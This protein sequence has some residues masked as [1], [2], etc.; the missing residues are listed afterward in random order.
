M[1]DFYY[2]NQQ[3]PEQYVAERRELQYQ[4]KK[5]K[6]K[7]DTLPREQQVKATIKGRTLLIDNVPQIKS[8]R[9]PT[10]AEVMESHKE[11]PQYDA[12]MATSDITKEK[13]SVFVSYA[14]KV[15]TLTHISSA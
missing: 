13:G 7:N 5:I 2:I 8:I 11:D 3:Y 9:P 6:A 10:I 1:N 15:K 4:L 14:V 12:K